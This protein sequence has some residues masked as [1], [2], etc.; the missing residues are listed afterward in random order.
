[1]LVFAFGLACIASS[2]GVV[3]EHP[4]DEFLDAL[5][6][7]IPGLV[8]LCITCPELAAAWRDPIVMD[9]TVCGKKKTF[10]IKDLIKDID[11]TEGLSYRWFRRFGLTVDVVRAK[12]LKRD[13]STASAENYKARQ[14][15]YTTKA[16]FN[17]VSIEKGAE[18]VLLCTSAG[19]V[20][21]VLDAAQPPEQATGNR[22][23][24]G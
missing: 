5:E 23:P 22:T 14:E 20:V 9:C 18:V 24:A 21:A 11:E 8:L 16:V 19:F 13:G 12:A 3:I 17:S 15:L 1:M 4:P 2:V 7:V 6:S 10:R